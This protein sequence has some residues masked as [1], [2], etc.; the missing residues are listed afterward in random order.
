MKNIVGTPA[1]GENFFHREGEI[2]KVF[3]RIEAGNNLQIAA[4]RRVGKTSI[5]HYL[6]D[7]NVGGYLYVYVDTER[8][9]S[10]QEFYKKLLKTIVKTDAVASS[11]RLKNLLKE[12]GKF[13][14][15]IRSIQVM[16]HGIDF[17]DDSA[18][19]DY[20]E[21]LTNFL[22]GFELDETEKL[23]LLIDEFPQTILNI[24]D[25]NE[26][27][28]QAAIRFLQS[29]RELR[30][31]PDV[32]GRVQFVYTGSIG[33]NHTVAAINGSAFVN[34][35]NSTEVEPLTPD[36]AYELTIELLHEKGISVDDATVAHLLQKIR[37]L[38][39]FHIQLSVQEIGDLCRQTKAATADTVDKAFEQMVASRNNNH[40]EHYYSRLN[41]QFKGKEA[42]YAEELLQRAATNGSIS[43]GEIYDQAVAFDVTGRYRQVLEVLTYDGYINNNS[44][45]QA[46][47][48]N[49]PVVRMWWQ[50]FICK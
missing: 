49:S 28:T 38:I 36:E 42:R 8:V 27:D 17:A 41:S 30:M 31:N 15:R 40:F 45:P 43:T 19:P 21:E 2:E 29:N 50:N 11:N 35:L 22:S 4:P 13:L 46:Y 10:E 47:E 20:Y 12:G 5:L 23:V 7:N 26:G 1:M 25:A 24:I 34:D 32:M 18:A 33:L 16:G 44:Q 9:D 48:F 37:W 39:P 6:K 14:K 3:S